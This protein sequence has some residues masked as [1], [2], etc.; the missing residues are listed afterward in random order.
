MTDQELQA[1][2]AKLVDA[3][4]RDDDQAG[5]EAALALGKA[6]VGAVLRIADAMEHIGRNMAPIA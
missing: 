4:K 3:I 2:F 6:V 5:Q 1:T